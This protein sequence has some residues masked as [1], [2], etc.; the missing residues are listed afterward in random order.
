M[1]RSELKLWGAVGLVGLVCLAWLGVAA[2]LL[3]A[4]LDPEDWSAVLDALGGRAGLLLFLWAMALI[5]VHS[6]LNYLID[7]YVRAPARLAE[8]ARMRLESNDSRPIEAKGSKEI[9]ALTSVINEA[10]E[11]REALV[12]AM[13]ERVREAARRTEQEKARLAALMSELTKSVVVCNLDGRILLYNNR[14]RLQFKRLSSSGAVTGGSELMG[15]GR[16]IYTVLDRKLV[17]HALENVQRRLK[18]GAASPS[19]QF[20]TA[21]AS[22]KLLRV[23]MTP[24][25]SVDEHGRAST[26]AMTG[27]VLL[28]ENIT[29]DMRADAEKSRLLSGLTEGSRASLANT[30]AAIEILEDPELDEPMR[31]RLFKVIREEVQGLSERIAE[32]QQ[33]TSEALRSRWPLEDMLGSDLID[34][35]ITR[36]ESALPVRASREGDIDTLWL[37]IESFSLLQG[38]VHLATRIHQHCQARWINLRLQSHK[39]RAMLDLV[40]TPDPEAKAE[41][42]MNW[43][44]EAISAGEDSLAMTL[45]DVLERHGGDCWIE[46][47]QGNDGERCLFRLLLPLATPQDELPAATFQRHE[48]RPEFYDFDLFQSGQRDRKLDDSP[49]RELSYTVFDTETT[50]LN[51]AGGDEIIQIGAVRIVN[52]K[53]LTQ[54]CFDQL[55][56]PRRSIPRASIPIH[57]ITPDMVKGQPAIDEVLPAFHAFC[58]DTVLVAHNAAFDMKCLEV[59]QAQTGLHFDQ[60][61]LDTLLLSALVQENQER[62]NL[63]DLAERFG[64]TILGRHTAIGDAMVTAEI[65]LRLIPLLAD[66]GIHTLGEALEASRKTWYARVKY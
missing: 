6:A 5:P 61:V 40:W 47:E 38:L 21:T 64:L 36:I 46:R 39:E 63:D 18:R 13:D 16:S 10:I 19:A 22:G 7:E 51:P 57:G 65:L 34:A 52:G 4:I 20:V 54:E 60:P 35:A 9:R 24:V 2:L 30:R 32:L 45:K 33:S 1:K 58:Q 3:W 50:G 31:E 43:E 26:D 23:Q 37:K 17:S 42:D 15:L 8:E 53:I 12:T 62:H 66:R 41:P 11:Q 14:A 56:D 25:R 55:V 59:K 44:N 28:T 48:G 27:F 29:D 49:L